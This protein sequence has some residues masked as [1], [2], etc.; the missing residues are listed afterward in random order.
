MARAKK[1]SLDMD[2]PVVVQGDD[3][4]EALVAEPVVEP[5]IE[6]VVEKAEHVR[7]YAAAAGYHKAYAV[8]ENVFAHLFEREL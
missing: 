6:P 8:A 1:S 4:D 3:V 7:A 5:V 2:E